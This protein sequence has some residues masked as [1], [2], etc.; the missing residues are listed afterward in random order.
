MKARKAHTCGVLRTMILPSAMFLAS[1]A[2]LSAFSQLEQDASAETTPNEAT[3][4]P[5]QG[6]K[7]SGSFRLSIE[8]ETV[9]RSQ[10]DD[11]LEGVKPLGVVKPWAL[12]LDPLFKGPT[13]K[14]FPFPVDLT[15]RDRQLLENLDYR[16]SGTLSRLEQ[17]KKISAELK[18]LPPKSDGAV[19]AALNLLRL[20]EEQALVFG[21]MRVVGVVDPK[22]PDIEQ[23]LKNI[24]RQQAQKYYDLILNHPKH[25]NLRQWKFSQLIARLRL[26]DPSVRDEA[27]ALIK[28]ANPT[29]ARELSAVG[30]AMDAGAGRL[31]S[32]F[33]TLEGMAQNS[34]D[35][36]ETAAI[37]LVLA[38]Q[39]LITNK[40]QQAIAVLQEV[41]ATCKGIRRGDKDQTPS[42]ILQAAA[43]T[44]IMAGLKGATST[45]LEVTQTLVNNDLI[46]YARSYLEQFALANY[47]KNPALAIKAYGETLA[48]GVLSSET[49]NKIEVRLLDLNISSNDLRFIQLAWERAISRGI[50]KQV[51]LDSQMVQTLNMMSMKFKAK[52]DKVSVTQMISFHDLFTKGFPAYAVREDHQLRILDALYQTR[53]YSDVIKRSENYVARF[54]DKDNRVAAL[55]Y[56]LNSR[57]QL[58][59]LGAEIKI[60]PS[61][62]IAGEPAIASGYVANSD[63]LR[64]ILPPHEGEVHLYTSAFVQLLSG[65]QKLAL[66]RYEEAFNKHPRNP[67]ASDSAYTLLEIL[68][69]RKELL[70]VEKF[71]RMFVK[72]GLIPSKDPYKDLPR[73]LEKTVFDIASQNFEAKQFEAAAIRYSNFQKEFGNSANAALALERAGLGFSQANKSEQALAVFDSYLRLYPKNPAAKEI[74]W[75]SAEMYV[76]I[77]QH[78][79]AAEHFQMYNQ[80][81]PSEAAQKNSALRAA[82]NFRTAGRISES[83]SE[84]EKHL[85]NQKSL[86]EQIKTLRLIAELAVKGN[87]QMI[88]LS[89]LERLSKLVKSP[90]DVIGV[91]FNLMNVYQKMGRDE[92]S[93]KSANLILVTRP[94]TPEGFKLQSKA[95]LFSARFDASVIKARQVMNQKDLKLAL[96]TLFKDY[97]KIK[98]D[99]LAPCEIPGVDWCAIGYFEA[100][101]LAAEVSKL[102]NNIEPS[103]YLDERVVAEI[104]SLVTWNKDKLRSESRSFALQAEEALGSVSLADQDMVDKIKMHIQQVKMRGSDTDGGDELAPAGGPSS[105]G[106]QDSE[107]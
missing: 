59:G 88:A 47:A 79:K 2:P 29:E 85:Q 38:E 80:L 9:E 68:T 18:K 104:K 8:E 94:T 24:R 102:L 70:E 21:W 90:D 62:K 103:A 83:L 36:Y 52:P 19:T 60:T 43:S 32:P 46:E 93:R 58:M 74:R 53:Q 40:T 100:S 91:Q 49:R 1:L 67:N 63:K 51:S 106:K 72:I 64:S 42:S 71:I 98:A 10:E 73:M 37:K 34:T 17:I 26:G 27:L 5:A 22:Y 56:N 23:S 12:V 55:T 48:F 82:E 25:P 11:S 14:R 50:Q 54:K 7:S 95:K 86:P 31:P 77:K 89:A 96:Q 107:F 3:T 92:P 39:Y 61:S 15:A 69:Q 87:N 35:Q 13:V 16:P 33:G 65:P 101:K 30:L 99:L 41:I 66:V 20:Y 97:E 44:L 4:R 57:S 81:Y 76:S 28:T 84:Y 6:S 78:L 105:V 45:N 75:T